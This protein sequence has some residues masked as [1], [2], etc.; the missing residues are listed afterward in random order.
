MTREEF[1][2][3]SRDGIN[4]LHAVEWKPS[5]EK[6]KYILQI[7]HGMS[8]YALCYNEFATFLAN[9]GILVVAEDHLGHGKSVT[10]DGITGYF[11]KQDP[12]TVLVRDVH[13]LKKLTQEKYKGIPYYILGHSMGSFILR[14]YICCYG[15][16]IE[17][18]IIMGTGKQP[19]AMVSTG[20][21]LTKILTLLQGEKHKSKIINTIAFGNFNSKVVNPRTQSDWLTTNEKSVDAYVAD[22]MRGFTFTLNGYST[23]FT[24][25]KRLYEQTYLEKMPK[26][27]PIL[28]TSGEMDPVGDYGK[29]VKVVYEDFKELGMKDITIKLYPIYRHEILNEVE[30]EKV[31]E[32]IFEWMIKTKSL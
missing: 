12:A 20:L 8:E 19:K 6:P 10:I 24:L 29:T 3:D 28:M 4:K 23:I 22:P 14:N 13:R 15:T 11:C 31:Y 9:K 7:V 1:Y 5:I 21:N 26:E 30:N 2:F 25:M 16:G 32:D 18:A 17:G 27:L